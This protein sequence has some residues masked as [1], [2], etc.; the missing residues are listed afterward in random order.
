[1]A[2]KILVV[3]DNVTILKM[4][5]LVL[6]SCGYEVAC[7]MDGASALIKFQQM[8]PDMLIL[9]L[10]MPAASGLEVYR[11]LRENLAQFIP[12]LFITGRPE[13]IPREMILSGDAKL[14]GKPV[15]LPMLKVM[16][17]QMIGA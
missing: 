17:Q 3:D 15:K 11:R 5:Y 4:Y 12:V 6:T 7:A 2:K 9:D 13:Q 8:K 1:M 10:E 14:L 16:V